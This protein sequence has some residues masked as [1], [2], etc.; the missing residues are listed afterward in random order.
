MTSKTSVANISEAQ[1]IAGP[2]S[3]PSSSPAVVTDS[4]IKFFL[5]GGLS[6]SFASSIMHPVDTVKV[7]CQTL[8]ETRGC[9]GERRLVNPFQVSKDIWK[10]AGLR[11][12][13]QGIDSAIFRQ[14][15][16]A[17]GR[18][19]IYKI[20][21][22]MKIKEVG[23]VTFG[24]KLSYSLIAGF[25]GACI[26]NPADLTMVRR[27]SDLALAP[28][29]RRNYGNVFSSLW[30]VAREEGLFALWKG[31]PFTILRVCA[32][33]SGQLTTFDEVKERTRKWRG[34]PDDIY[35]RVAA[36]GVS[37][38]LGSCIALPFDNIKVKF[39]K[40]VQMPDGTWPYK[41]LGDVIVK[42]IRREGL[43]GFWS[44]FPA[45]FFSVGPHTLLILIVQ[46]YLHIFLQKRNKQH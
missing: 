16:Y 17:A 26:G 29:L 15:T 46:D 4:K 32:L 13:Y 30:R 14:M 21:F 5:V 6:G 42:T 10:N 39:Q 2:G 12:F 36:A 41:N 19:G 35:N 9:H 37:G 40:M 20:L 1:R 31:T 7:H 38:F 27:Q 24:Q 34:K 25:F 23:F 11:G 28:E 18:L 8:N 43:P 3:S 44:G 45:F 33:T 22:D